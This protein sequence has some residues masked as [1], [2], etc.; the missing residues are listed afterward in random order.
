M[1]EQ[2]SLSFTLSFSVNYNATFC[3]LI[4]VGQIGK[5]LQEDKKSGPN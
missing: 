4:P 1:T 3:I 2:F 5:S